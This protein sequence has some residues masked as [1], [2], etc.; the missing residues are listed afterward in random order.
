MSLSPALPAAVRVPKEAVPDA[1]AL[2][3]EKGKVS[4]Q[5]ALLEAMGWLLDCEV[6]AGR[7][8]QVAWLEE[9]KVAACEQPTKSNKTRHGF[10]RSSYFRT[11][12]FK[13]NKASD[14]DL[15]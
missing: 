4:L 10:I 8:K 12:W 7:S 5:L 6:T 14:P 13:S 1:L 2:E 9:L 3:R 15:G 11:N